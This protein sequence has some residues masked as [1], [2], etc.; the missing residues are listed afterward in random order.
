MTKLKES[1]KNRKVYGNYSVYSPDGILMF[2]SNI[3]KI[4]WYLNR[5][6]AQKIDEFSIKLTFTPNGLGCH[7]VGYGLERMK[8]ICV[9]CGGHEFL[10]KHHVVPKCYRIHFPEKIKSHKFH[11]VLTVCLDCH[12]EYEELAFSYKKKIA[13]DYNSPINGNVI[14]NKKTQ[15][16][17]GLFICLTDSQIPK[18]R[19]KEI[20]DEIKSEL[21]I[22]KIT[23][24]LISKWMNH[25]SENPFVCIKTHG[26][27]VV[28]KL[29]N[30]KEFIEKWR[31]HFIE[32]A[33]PKF[34]PENWSINYE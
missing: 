9:I 24:K 7:G 19:L 32:N 2:R 20:K 13:D 18:N 31:I 22:K 5:N 11:D 10:T 8:N 16:I 27:M 29:E 33:N 30:I 21:G 28:Q 34:L 23:N 3:K 12:Y 17:K 4:N 15:K 1:I 25:K 6:L 26:E 14:S